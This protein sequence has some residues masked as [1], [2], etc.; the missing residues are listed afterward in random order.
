M[1]CDIHGWI[2]RKVGDKYVAIKELGDRA[3]ARNYRRFA[4]LAGVRGDGPEPR[5]VPPN[6]SETVRYWID[7]WD[8][9]GHSHSWLPIKE[10][11]EV[12]AVDRYP[13]MGGKRSEY[14]MYEYFG[15]DDETLEPDDR[16]VF[17]FDN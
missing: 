16:V 5:G 14:P 4:A 9:D 2:E 11:C 15:M 17:W 13:E 6:V 12:W 1:G 7:T 10:A 3:T 8:S